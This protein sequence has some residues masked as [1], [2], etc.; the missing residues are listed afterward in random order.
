M[1]VRFSGG[2]GR[3]VF[4]S[5]LSG[6]GQVRRVSHVLP[7]GKI[8]V[9]DHGWAGAAHGWGRA[10]VGSP[11]NVPRRGYLKEGGVHAE[12]DESASGAGPEAAEH[13]DLA[14]VQDD[15]DA[16]EADLDDREKK[17]LADGACSSELAALADERDVLANQRDELAARH[18]SRAINRDH[19]SLVRDV[20]ASA[21]DVQARAVDSDADAGFADRFLSARDRDDAA[22]DRAEAVNDRARSARSRE[23]AALQRDRAAHDRAEAL[24][25]EV[26]LG[27][28]LATLKNALDT[29]NIIGQAQGLLM[30]RHRI[31]GDDAFAMLVRLSQNTHRKLRD[32]AAHVVQL[33]V[34][35]HSD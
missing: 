7:N 14:V 17:A 18:D 24:A 20:R 23:R 33:A 11:R 2:I 8:A 4:S 9:S 30:A 32:V 15:L 31:N 6:R 34:R 5:F 19:A 35:D 25:R 1:N 13:D 3:S 16:A 28:Q 22:A 10:S 12:H 27:N 29:R 21:R 26:G